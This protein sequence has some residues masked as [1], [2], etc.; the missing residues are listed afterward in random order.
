[1]FK[2]KSN[3]KTK[4]KNKTMGRYIISRIYRNW[5]YRYNT[6]IHKKLLYS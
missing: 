6:K 4:Q 2:K 5:D 1:M 3:R